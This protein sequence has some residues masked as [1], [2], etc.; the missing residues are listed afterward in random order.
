M[1]KQTTAIPKA[2][3]A[4][5]PPPSILEPRAISIASPLDVGTAW[6]PY[7]TPPGRC[8]RCG[9]PRPVNCSVPEPPVKN[10]RG[11]FG[12]HGCAAESRRGSRNESRCEVAGELVGRADGYQS[13]LNED[14]PFQLAA[15]LPSGGAPVSS[16]LNRRDQYGTRKPAPFTDRY[17]LFHFLD[18]W[19]TIAIR[20]REKPPIAASPPA[21]RRK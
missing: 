20:I 9:L 19:R 8:D 17:R 14:G 13:F 18:P 15:L 4:R 16:H 2:I 5:W 7:P 6:T 12:G 1:M 21:P 3:N 10:D 11:T